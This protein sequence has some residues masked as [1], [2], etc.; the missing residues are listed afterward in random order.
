MSNLIQELTRLL[1]EFIMSVAILGLGWF[2]GQHLTVYWSLRQK[3]KELQISIAHEFQA[4][5]GEFFCSMEAVEL[6]HSGYWT[7][8]ISRHLSYN[9]WF[10]N[11]GLNFVGGYAKPLVRIWL[12]ILPNKVSWCSYCVPSHNQRTGGFGLARWISLKNRRRFTMLWSDPVGYREKVWWV[13]GRNKM[14]A[15]KF[16]RRW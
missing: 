4:R 5:Y 11:S 1:P 3:R 10:P 2:I 16:V 14:A 9:A 6:L 8:I 13:F 7:W 12:N 15:E